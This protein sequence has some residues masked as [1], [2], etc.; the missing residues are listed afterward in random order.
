[1]PKLTVNSY[2]P[3]SLKKVDLF[4]LYNS[5]SA[6]TGKTLFATGKQVREGGGKTGSILPVFVD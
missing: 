4:S 5:K 2:T 6:N 3:S 1:M